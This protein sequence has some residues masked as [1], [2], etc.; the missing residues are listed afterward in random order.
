[1]QISF[2]ARISSRIDLR[3]SP[4]VHSPQPTTP[5]KT[6]SPPPAKDVIFS[7]SG[8]F[9]VHLNLLY[10]RYLLIRHASSEIQMAGTPIGIAGQ[11]YLFRNLDFK[12]RKFVCT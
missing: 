6:F 12:L 2:N 11:K 8:P 3:Q 10:A 1:M 5:Q 9:Y 7:L 4:S